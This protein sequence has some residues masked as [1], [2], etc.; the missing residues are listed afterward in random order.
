M[1]TSVAAHEPS[2]SSDDPVLRIDA[3]RALRAIEQ[4]A[5]NPDDI[6]QGFVIVDSLAGQAPLRVLW[7]FRQDPAGRKLLVQRPSLLTTLNDRRSLERMGTDS[8]AH[9]YLKVL[10]RD[11]VT[12]DGLQAASIQ[13]RGTLSKPRSE[14]EFVRARIRDSHDLWHAVTGYPATPVGEIALLSFSVA[15]LRNPGIAVLVLAAL[16]G[17]REIAFSK[18]IM[19]AFLHGMRAAWLPPVRWETL[20]PLPLDEVRSILRVEPR[21]I[22]VAT[23]GVRQRAR[24]PAQRAYVTS[25]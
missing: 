7:R 16:A 20:L 12:A 11:G 6:A 13:G 25:A 1:S 23:L 14:F 18:V 2:S 8:L 5:R 24:P 3:K 22:D 17:A 19:G 9:E 21:P 4:L 15:Q 10:D